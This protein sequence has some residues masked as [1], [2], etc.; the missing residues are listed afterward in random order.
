M[1]YGRDGSGTTMKWIL[2]VL[3]G[4][5][6]AGCASPAKPAA[7]DDGS[8]DDFDIPEG[9]LA[10]K[11]VVVN[12]AI[13][14][15]EGATVVLDDGASARTTDKGAFVFVDVEPG[16]H[17]LKV[18]KPGFRETTTT[19]TVAGADDP[20]VRVLLEADPE[21]LPWHQ[22]TAVKGFLQCGIGIPGG[23]SYSACQT[24]VGAVDILCDVSG[25]A[26]CLPYVNDHRGILTIDV[27]T[28]LPTYAQAEAVWNPTS[29]NSDRLTWS[30]AARTPGELEFHNSTSFTGPSPLLMPWD[31]GRLADSDVGVTRGFVFQVFPESGGVGNLVLQ[32]RVELFVTVFYN[33]LPPEGWSL[34]LD[35]EPE[36]PR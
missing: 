27:T 11:G 36:P 31:H 29:P 19:A 18:T 4:L 32:Q 16:V 3:A 6:L 2:P 24:P 34:A 5:I 22:I 23:G 35:G 15:L 33:Y 26:V 10:L 8:F 30:S 14:P 28:G 1:V 25:D 13:V 20:I 7:Q 21:N 9:T 12:Q 17:V